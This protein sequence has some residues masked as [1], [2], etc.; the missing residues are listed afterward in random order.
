MSKALK[1]ILP[2][3]PRFHCSPGLDATLPSVPALSDT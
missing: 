1:A 3:R 2:V